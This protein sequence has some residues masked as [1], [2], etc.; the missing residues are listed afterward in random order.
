[1]RRATIF[2][3]L[4]C[5]TF[6]ASFAKDIS[7][8]DCFKALEHAITDDIKSGTFYLVDENNKKQVS[9]KIKNRSLNGLCESYFKNGQAKFT[10]NFLNNKLNGNAQSFDETGN[11][12]RLIN[13]KNNLKH[14]TDTVFFKSGIKKS[15]ISYQHGLKNGTENHFNKNG[16]LA[17]TYNFIN[18]KKQYKPNE[19]SLK[20]KITLG[21]L[22]A[23]AITGLVFLAVNDK[24]IG[25]NRY[26][27]SPEDTK[28]DSMT[29]LYGCIYS[30]RG[31]CS[32]HG[33]IFDV[34]GNKILCQDGT[35]SPSCRCL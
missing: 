1:M 13:Y 34:T 4:I 16:S 3:I 21:I 19:Y 25:H 17:K 11:K 22:A 14:G 27:L 23:T 12:I 35:I 5:L 2:L 29:Q 30:L 28:A 7:F 18:N 33:G 6:Q 9:I 31:C 10:A 32:Y 15:E 26:Y 20:K 24:G 8:N